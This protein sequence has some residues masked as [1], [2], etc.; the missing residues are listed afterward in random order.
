MK[1]IKD[2]YVLT[3]RLPVT[4]LNAGFIDTW[5]L[6]IYDFSAFRLF[7]SLLQLCILCQ[8]CYQGIVYIVDGVLRIR[9]HHILVL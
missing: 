2:Y 1:V 3:Y 4:F 6:L 5:L 9:I 8:K 7:E